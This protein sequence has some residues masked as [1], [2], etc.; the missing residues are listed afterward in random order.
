MVGLGFPFLRVWVPALWAI[1]FSWLGLGSR[2]G[3][4]RCVAESRPVRGLGFSSG[5][6]AT[7]ACGSRTEDSSLESRPA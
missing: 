3:F 6:P 2:G 7:L 5:L 4:G 1:K